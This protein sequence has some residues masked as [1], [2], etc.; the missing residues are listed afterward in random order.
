MLS[1]KK[2]S[3]SFETVKPPTVG[4]WLQYHWRTLVLYSGMV[5]GV[6][7]CVAGVFLYREYQNNQGL[8]FLQEGMVLLQQG[9]EREATVLLEDAIGRLRKGEPRMLA[10]FFLGKSLSK[11][12]KQEEEKQVYKEIAARAETTNY[13]KQFALME[14]AQNAEK[15]QEFSQAQQFYKEAAAIEGP[16][17]GLALLAEARILEQVN[18]RDMAQLVYSRFLEEYTDSPL[19]EIVQQKEGK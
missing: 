14:L 2:R 4:D 9:K 6:I 5:L 12:Q 8:R 17:Q 16:A 11:Q 19:I 10:L 1:L 7:I 15:D 13:I 3:T 18:D